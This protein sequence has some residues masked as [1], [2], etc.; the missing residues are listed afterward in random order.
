MMMGLPTGL[1]FGSMAWL[2]APATTAPKHANLRLRG[3]VT[4]LMRTAARGLPVGLAV[5]LP[6]ALLIAL[7]PP[8]LVSVWTT[9]Y[10]L[11]FGTTVGLVIGLQRFVSSEDVAQRST[12]PAGSYRGDRARA[13]IELV[14]TGLAL[15]L[16]RASF[17]GPDVVR[18]F[19]SV[20]ATA[21]AIGLVIG[22]A[23]DAWPLFILASTWR[24]LR[25]K[26]P[27]PSRVMPFLDDAYRLGLLRTVGPAY[28]F[29]HAE[30]QDHLAPPT[31]SRQP[32]A[33]T[34]NTYSAAAGR[35]GPQA[36]L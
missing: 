2:V 9:L 4:E 13:L 28:Q 35:S 14:G 20:P 8:V 1:L 6:L 19:V 26:L 5:T 17:D 7:S 36:L 18:L 16:A 12:S 27:R 34:G 10:W 33:T 21:V 24:A 3:R 31:V 30:L 22:L 32:R 15:V 23:R 11:L 29:R 25:R